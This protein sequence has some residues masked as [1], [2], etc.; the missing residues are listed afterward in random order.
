MGVLSVRTVDASTGKIAPARIHLT[1]S[2]GKFYCPP[3]TYA[4]FLQGALDHAFHT[5]PVRS[6][7]TCPSVR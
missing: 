1:A 6:I 4:R 2:D 5:R 7:S 3:E